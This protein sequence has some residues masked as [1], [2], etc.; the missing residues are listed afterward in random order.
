MSKMMPPQKD[1]S[2]EA[3]GELFPH[4]LRSLD[5]VEYSVILDSLRVLEL[6][7]VS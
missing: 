3:T 4:V 6:F 1:P 5:R 7:E 2:G